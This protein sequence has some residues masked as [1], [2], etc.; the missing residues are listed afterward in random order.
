MSYTVTSIMPGVV[1]ANT[2]YGVPA[3][4]TEPNADA[5]NTPGCSPPAILGSVSVD[6]PVLG[7][8]YSLY[9][10]DMFPI[11]GSVP[12]TW[13]VVSGA[14]PTGLSISGEYITGTP[15]VPDE[16]G[17]FGLQVENACG[18]DLTGDGFT[19]TVL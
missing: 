2:V 9:I 13:T 11:S 18:T 17:T 4:V 5:G 8:A 3:P 16:V 12:R 19:L 1:R 7:V 15:T 10:P 6:Q 14:L